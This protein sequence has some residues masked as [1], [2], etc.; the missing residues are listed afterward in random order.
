M[1]VFPRKELEKQKKRQVRKLL[2]HL[3]DTNISTTATTLKMSCVSIKQTDT[4]ITGYVNSSNGSKKYEVRI[5]NR[6]KSTCTCDYHKFKNV[7]CKHIYITGLK[8]VLYHE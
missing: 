1:F 5:P 7:D 3:Q 2:I 6:G 8:Y 4:D